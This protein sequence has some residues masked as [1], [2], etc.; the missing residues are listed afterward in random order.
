MQYWAYW[1]HQSWNNSVT[2]KRKRSELTVRP[3]SCLMRGSQF[4]GELHTNRKPITRGRDL[5]PVK[6]AVCLVCL[7]TIASVVLFISSWNWPEN[8]LVM[9]AL[10]SSCPAICLNKTA[11]VLQKQFYSNIARDSCIICPSKL[12]YKVELNLTK[13]SCRSFVSAYL[14]D[15]W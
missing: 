12:T 1:L 7:V 15:V 8:D 14:C 11:I 10:H 13:S 9:L 4:R 5:N 6:I 2:K 3:W